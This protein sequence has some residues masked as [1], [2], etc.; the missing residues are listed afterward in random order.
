MIEKLLEIREKISISEKAH[1][2][3]HVTHHGFH[4][5]YL[6]AAFMEGHGLYS[7]AAGGLFSVVLLSLLFKLS[8]EE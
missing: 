4:L 6:G 2:V 5:T 1:G 8:G 7:L 3:A